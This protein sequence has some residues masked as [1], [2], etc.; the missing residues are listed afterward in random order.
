MRISVRGLSLDVSVDGPS[1]GPAVLLLHGF[2]QNATEWQ[3]VIPA[4]H[5]AGMRTIAPDQRGYSPGARPAE[6][7]AYVM[8]ECVADAVAL[9]DNLGIDRTHVVGHDWGAVVAW[10]LAADFPDRV[11]TLTAVSVPHPTAFTDAIDNDADQQRRS[12]Y[13]GLFRKAGHAEDVLLDD[14]GARLRAMF[15]GCP[16]ELIDDYVTP[17]LDRATLTGALNWYRAMSNASLAAGDVTVP[18][19]YVWGDS[20]PAVGAIAARACARYVTDDYRFVPLTGVG[21]WIPDEVPG[22]MAEA[23]LSRIED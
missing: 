11:H 13:F 20:D 16:P 21:H 4:L 19:T 9:L 17:M 14:N 22:A 12:S 3:R 2:P 15:A 23:I 5:A 7:D 10:R 1:D 8:K 18:T 6:V